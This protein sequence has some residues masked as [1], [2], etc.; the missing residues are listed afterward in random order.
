[1][2]LI[3]VELTCKAQ[4][5]VKQMDKAEMVIRQKVKA[6]TEVVQMDVKLTGYGSDEDSAK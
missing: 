3:G 6:N 5:D 2:T 1:M 4:V